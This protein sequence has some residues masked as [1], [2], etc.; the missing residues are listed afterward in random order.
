MK[1]YFCNFKA[2]S[3]LTRSFSPLEISEKAIESS[4]ETFERSLGVQNSILST[5]ESHIAL[6]PIV[7]DKKGRVEAMRDKVK[8][9]IGESTYQK[10]Q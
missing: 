3:N 4:Q 1:V 8:Q 9:E 6:D 7:L 2:V 5:A 10:V